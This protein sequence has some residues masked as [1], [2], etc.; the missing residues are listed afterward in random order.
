MHLA[1][2]GEAPFGPGVL[3]CPIAVT[4]FGGSMFKS[5]GALLALLFVVLMTLITGLFLRGMIIKDF[6]RYLEGEHVDLARLVASDIEGTYEKHKRWNRED[7]AGDAVRALM[8]G[9]QVRVKDAGNEVVM[10]TGKALALLPPE[11]KARILAAVEFSGEDKSADYHSYPLFMGGERGGGLDVKFPRTGKEDL[12]IKRSGAFVLAWSFFM[13][14]PALALGILILRKSA[15]PIRKP[16]QAAA[17]SI[18]DLNEDMPVPGK[19][20]TAHLPETGGPKPGER[21]VSQGRSA[22]STAAVK[23]EEPEAMPDDPPDAGDEDMQPI[24]GDA[25]RI[26]KIVEGLDALAKAQ[27]PGRALQKQ[28]LELAQYLNGII[29][30]A[31]GSVRDKDVTFN[32]ECESGLRLKTDPVCLAGIMTNLLDNA[33]KAVK[34]EGTVFVSAVAKGDRVVFAVRDTGTGIRRKDLPHIFERFYRASGSGI[35]LG[36]T[37]VQELVDACGGTIEVQTTWGKGSTVTVC[38]PFS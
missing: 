18:A 24:P 20:E 3:T 19:D 5:P 28:P 26:K 1:I 17:D 33:A 4:F 34:K 2:H 25:D 6:Q 15:G 9:M 37:I 38:I 10:D 29:E 32:L 12:F 7:T 22:F 31:R 23:E 13:A 8:L 27:A 16:V 21:S 30:K 35:G 36:L 14:G 11:R